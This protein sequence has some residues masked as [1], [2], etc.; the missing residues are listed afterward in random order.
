MK[1]AKITVMAAVMVWVGMLLAGSAAAAPEQYW[2]FELQFSGKGIQVETDAA[3][4]TLPLY[5]GQKDKLDK[6]TIYAPAILN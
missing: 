5:A 6:K 2:Y 4:E 3:P 1:T